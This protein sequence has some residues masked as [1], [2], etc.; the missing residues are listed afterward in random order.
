VC[1]VAAL[2]AEAY[3]RRY[4]RKP[5]ATE[6]AVILKKSAED[7]VGPATDSLFVWNSETRVF[8]LRAN[9]PSDSPGKDHRYRFGRVNAKKAIEAA[10]TLHGE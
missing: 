2:A 9:E 4:G 5:S 6:L 8:D 1:G 7:M 10:Q 3:E